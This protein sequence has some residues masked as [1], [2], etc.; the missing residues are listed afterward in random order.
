M[1]IQL[2]NGEWSQGDGDPFQSINPAT[3]K[4]IWDGHCATPS[5]VSAAIDAAEQA[6]EHWRKKDFESRLNI[7][8]QYRSLLESHADELAEAIS[9]EV[10]KPRWE[11]KTEVTAA[12]GKVGISIDAYH[13]R[14]GEHQWEQQG[15]KFSYHHRPH[16]VLAVF[17]PFNFPL[18]LPNG[19]IVPALLAGNTVVLKP[20]E[21]TPLTS[22]LMTE[23]WCRA[24]IPNGVINLVQGD[25]NTGKALAAHPKLRGLLFTGS[26]QVG[27]ELHRQFGGHPEKLLALEMGGNNPLVVTEID[28][29]DACAYNIIQSAFITTGQRCTCAR[30]LIVVKENNSA[31]LIEKVLSVTEN[32]VIGAYTDQPEPFIGP[33]ISNSAADR[34]I[35]QQN[36]LIAQG[37]TELVMA[38]RPNEGLPFITPGIID[39]TKV[40][41]RCDDECFGPLLQL[42][43][44]D[45]LDAA[46]HEANSTGYGLSSGILT[47]NP[48]SYHRFA[49]DSQAGLINWNRP[50]TGA[51]S[52]APFGGTGLSG[53][54]KPSGYY[55]A[56]YC[57][58]PVASSYQ[59]RLTL[60]TSLSPGIVIPGIENP[61]N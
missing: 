45:S 35:Q 32:L 58:Y 27:R 52:Q 24:G 37:G 4:V 28:D 42:I 5:E 48:E 20:S 22:Q 25:S 51:S 3:G 43:L 15:A 8:N 19:H 61:G 1:T 53:N 39:V 41:N 9:K 59:D 6:F 49:C 10:G 44:V 17:G 55:A 57:A 31:A 16:G 50:L 21:L 38:K 13:Q 34:V 36:H 30:R 12:I 23:L 46:I 40:T 11:A 33:V 29:I 56:D 7:I 47:N 14:T 2:I 26:Y 18:H 60:P 54:F